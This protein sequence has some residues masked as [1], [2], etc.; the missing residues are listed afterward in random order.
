M[1]N[2]FVTITE[3]LALEQAHRADE[4]LARGIDRGPLHGIPYA[5]KDMFETRGI[6]TTCGSSLFADHIPNRDAAVYEKLTEAGAVLMGK[7]GLHEL[8]YG[9]TS[10]N[11]H[12]GAVR[13]PR[14][15]GKVPGGSSGGSGA[16]VSAG[17]IPFAMGSDT[18]GSIRIPAA[19]C[20]CVGLKPTSGRVSRFGT[21]PLDYSLDHMG[22]LTRSVEDAAL[23]LNAIAGFD[24]RDDT[25]S[26]Q[27]VPDYTPGA[28]TSLR[29]VRI[30][31]AGNFFNERMEPGIRAAFEQTAAQIAS[32]GAEIVPV[33]LP[34]PAAITTIGRVILLSEASSL[35]E[36]Y[37]ENRSAFG[38]DVIALID[39][40]RMIAAT[41]Y[42]NAQRLRRLYQQRWAK[43]WEQI[44]VLLVPATPNEAP[45]VGQ[46]TVSLD[47]V[48]EEVRLTSTRFVRCFN[49][50]GNPA[51]SIPYLYDNSH[52]LSGFQLVAAPFQEA[53][54]LQ[55][56]HAIQPDSSRITDLSGLS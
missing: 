27:P 3:D 52:L 43:V 29:G 13:N 41:D 53:Q 4:E 28:G 6:R 46:V 7:T 39:Q 34:D 44:D 40:G 50:L 49:V 32:K 23:V 30:G 1:L 24:H 10:N 31:I 25:S 21:L 37:A 54:L 51:L 36:Q 55:I 14:D 9:I 8:A 47:G 19:F 22:P 12:F 42:I 2:A 11:P 18:G 56:G 20:G 38:S 26:R 15:V 5:L 33:E 16:A 48:E 17:L 45:A 35:L